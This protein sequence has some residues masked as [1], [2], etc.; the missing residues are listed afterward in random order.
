MLK[1]LFPDVSHFLRAMS[2][3]RHA[4]RSRRRAQGVEPS[5]V[6][7]GGPFGAALLH[8]VF[9]ELENSRYGRTPIGRRHI[10]W[11]EELT[12]AIRKDL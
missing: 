10:H 8:R 6:Q 11:I 4:D 1:R 7:V 5:I 3:L 12:E 2:V 9:Y